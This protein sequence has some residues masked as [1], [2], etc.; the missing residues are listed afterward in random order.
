MLATKCIVHTLRD[1]H[2]TQTVVDNL[3]L[4]YEQRRTNQKTSG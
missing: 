2:H 4:D 1:T 3:K